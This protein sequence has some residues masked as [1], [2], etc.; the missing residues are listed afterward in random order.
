MFPHAEAGSGM[1]AIS[2]FSKAQ[3]IFVRHI[4]A[5]QASRGRARARLMFSAVEYGDEP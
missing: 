1:S 3:F 2:Q 4:H 5:W